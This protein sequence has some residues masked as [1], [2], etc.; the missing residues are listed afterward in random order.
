[1][2]SLRPAPTLAARGALLSPRSVRR[3]DCVISGWA[4]CRGWLL[5]LMS[6]ERGVFMGRDGVCCFGP[7]EEAG[8]LY[9]VPGSRIPPPPR[10]P[11]SDLLLEDLNG[12][13]S[14]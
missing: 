7:G 1:M 10:E 14:I 9:E 11:L 13:I 12:T 3:G 4:F 8:C 6:S 5:I 2:E